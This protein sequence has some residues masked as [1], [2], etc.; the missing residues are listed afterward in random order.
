M[1]GGSALVE[2]AS[3]SVEGWRT[4]VDGGTALPEEQAGPLLLTDG[5]LTTTCTRQVFKHTQYVTEQ[6]YSHTN[7]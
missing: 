7:I 2:G 3:A 5:G 6:T 1:E 4:T